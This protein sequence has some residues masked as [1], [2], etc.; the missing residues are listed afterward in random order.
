[1]MPARKPTMTYAEYLVFEEKS[2]ERHI[3]VYRRNEA[4]RWELYEYE[5]GSHV[6][7]AS[8]GCKIAV[9]DV[10]RDPLA[11]AAAAS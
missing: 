5:S 11:S 7:L 2:V 4:G 8:V 3:E 10:Y 6:E 9:D 1:M